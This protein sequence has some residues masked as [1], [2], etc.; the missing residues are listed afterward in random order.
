MPMPRNIQTRRTPRKPQAGDPTVGA[1]FGRRAAQRAIP[2]ATERGGPATRRGR[3]GGVA[4]GRFSGAPTT[5]RR[6]RSSGRSS[7]P[8][9]RGLLGA[10]G[11]GPQKRSKG[12]RKG[13][14][15]LAVLAGLGAAGAGVLKRRRSGSDQPPT[16]VPPTKE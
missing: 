1:R 15:L 8:L 13:P 4:P 7:N 2:F 16:Y 14:A 9:A 6:T 10:L 3:F 11:S 12:S 5:M